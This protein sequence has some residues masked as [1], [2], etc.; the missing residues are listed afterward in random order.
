LVELSAEFVDYPN[1]T[2][3]IEQSLD[4]AKVDFTSL[5]STPVT[6]LAHDMNPNLAA[7]WFN[8]LVKGQYHLKRLLAKGYSYGR[9]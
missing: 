9:R 5:V 8:I 3:E 4:G 7:R 1:G 2:I 6:T